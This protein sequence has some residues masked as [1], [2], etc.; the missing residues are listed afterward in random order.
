MVSSLPLQRQS[1]QDTMLRPQKC[2]K[3]VFRGILRFVKMWKSAVFGLI[4]KSVWSNWLLKSAS[5]NLSRNRLLHMSWTHVIPSSII[6]LKFF[7]VWFVFC[8]CFFLLFFKNGICLFCIGYWF[9][10]GCGYVQVT[11]PTIT[12]LRGKH[13]LHIVAQ[14]ANCLYTNPSVR[15]NTDCIACASASERILVCVRMWSIRP[16]HWD[17]SVPTVAALTDS[18]CWPLTWEHSA[19]D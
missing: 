6:W 10:I 4:P 18:V 9:N 5:M 8:F 11:L 1:V 12:P 14:G 16:C 2:E 19:F 3:W 7:L 13:S 15:L 17:W